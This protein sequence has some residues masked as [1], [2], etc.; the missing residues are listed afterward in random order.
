MRLPVPPRP[1]RSALKAEAPLLY[2][3]ICRHQRKNT[4]HPQPNCPGAIWLVQTDTN[5][6]VQIFWKV[7][8]IPAENSPNRINGVGISDTSNVPFRTIK[9]VNSPTKRRRALI[10]SCLQFRSVTDKRIAGL[11]R[12]SSCQRPDFAL[13]G[14]NIQILFAQ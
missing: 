9:P 4:I 8:T 10:I 3:R 14:F 6:A 13:S 12:Q 1:L 11:T 5:L 7:S 2:H